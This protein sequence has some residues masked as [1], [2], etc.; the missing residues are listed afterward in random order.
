MANWYKRAQCEEDLGLKRR[1][2]GLV[3]NVE[4]PAGTV[5]Y[6]IGDDGHQWQTKMQYDYGFIRRVT[7]SDGEGLDVY[8]GP[9]EDAE[10]VFVVHQVDPDSGEYDEDKVMLGFDSPEQAKQGYLV[11]YDRPDFF[12]KMSVLPFREFEQVIVSNKPCQTIVWKRKG[13]R[14]KAP[15]A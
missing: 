7:G 4:N 13:K 15:K 3:V 2:N 14:L 11:H 12:G 5:R 8:I 9:N 6:G 10:N 1:F